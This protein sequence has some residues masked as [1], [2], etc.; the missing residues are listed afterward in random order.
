MPIGTSPGFFATWEIASQVARIRGV[1]GFI[2]VKRFDVRIRNSHAVEQR[3]FLQL[4]IHQGHRERRVETIRSFRDDT[5]EA[6]A[7]ENHIFMVGMLVQHQ[8]C[9]DGHPKPGFRKIEIVFSVHK[10]LAFY[11]EF[12]ARRSARSTALAASWLYPSAPISSQNS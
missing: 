4:E 7:V 11:Q 3:F 5:A 10:T 1:R 6:C 9:A 2:E 12:S 8:M